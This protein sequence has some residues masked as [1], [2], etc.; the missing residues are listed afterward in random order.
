VQLDQLVL[1]QVVIL[2]EDVLMN[3]LFVNQ[4]DVLQ[5]TNVTQLLT[6]V[7]LSFQIVTMEMLVL[8]TVSF[9]QLD[10]FIPHFVLLLMLAQPQLVQTDN[11]P[12]LQRI[13]MTETFAQSTV[14][15]F[16]LDLVLTL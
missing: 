13:V 5:A 2:Q 12:T 4:L 10:V 3:L 11:A 14:V 7:N 8:L 9:Q 1:L 16:N 6:N 15:I